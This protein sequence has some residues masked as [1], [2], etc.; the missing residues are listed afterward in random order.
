MK[1]NRHRV[2]RWALAFPC[3]RGLANLGSTLRCQRISIPSQRVREHNAANAGNGPVD[4][5]PLGLW[6]LQDVAT[7]IHLT[8]LQFQDVAIFHFESYGQ[9]RVAR[10]FL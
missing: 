4:S 7:T 3:L 5:S 6:R 9:I 8:Q 2:I 10:N 1:A